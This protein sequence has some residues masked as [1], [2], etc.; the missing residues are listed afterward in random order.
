MNTG[1][2]I[3]DLNPKNSTPLDL[4]ILDGCPEMVHKLSFTTSELRRPR[5]IDSEYARLQLDIENE[6]GGELDS[7]TRNFSKYLEEEM[8]KQASWQ[9]HPFAASR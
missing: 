5:R 6:H 9:L 1:A 8:R 4:A 7:F 2:S 3:F